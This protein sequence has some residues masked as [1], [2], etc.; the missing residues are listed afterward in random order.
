MTASDSAPQLDLPSVSFFGRTLE[1]YARFFRLD[2]SLLAGSRVLDVAA[3]PASLTAE[4]N[5]LGVETVAVD[6]LYGCSPEGL[7][8]HVMLDYRAM[9]AQMRAKPELFR[10]G[11]ASTLEEVERSRRTAARRFLVDYG[12]HFVHGRYVGAGLPH[13][14]FAD[15]SFDLVLC[16]HFLFVYAHLYDLAFH[17][18][19]CRELVRVSRGEVR[20]YPVVGR[21]GLAYPHLDTLCTRLAAAGIESELIALDYEF[22]AGASKM[23]VLRRG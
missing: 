10:F 13:L 6:P 16:G 2:P 22:F 14:P 11:A 15:Q 20:I 1:E 17:E 7:E 19:A 5:R 3:G 8:Q 21:G 23:L 18:A 4:L 12:A 9:F